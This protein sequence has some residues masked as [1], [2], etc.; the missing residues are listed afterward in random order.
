MG[1]GTALISTPFWHAKELLAEGRGRLF[2]FRNFDELSTILMEMFDDPDLLKQYKQKSATFGQGIIWPVSGEEYNSMLELVIEENKTGIVTQQVTKTIAHPKISF[3]HIRKLTDQTGIISHAVYGFPNLKNGY[4]MEDNARALFAAA[5]A[6]RYTGKNNLKPLMSTYLSFI[7]F[8]QNPDG[9]FKNHLLYNHTPQIENSSDEC[10]GTV[11]WALGYL[12]NNPPD[13]S[14]LEGAKEIFKKAVTNTEMLSQIRGIAYSILGLY[15]Y[16]EVFKTDQ[17]TSERLY[18]LT[19][20]LTNQYRNTKNTDWN[21]FET[22]IAYDNAVLPLALMVS[23]E[24]LQDDESKKMAFESMRFLTDIVIKEGR[25]SLIG[26]KKWYEKD[27][28]RSVFDQLPVDAMGLI[29]LYKRAFELTQNQRFYQ[30]MQIC[31]NW[32]YGHNDLYVSLYDTNTRGCYDGLQENGV[33]HNQGA[34][35]SL[36]FVTSNIAMHEVLS[37]IQLISASKP[38]S[39]T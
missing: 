18:S 6:Y 22:K 20:K 5:M 10:F 34:E 25:L 28:E 30:F 27:G 3:R 17:I 37:Q 23:S 32:F 26:N 21:W 1:A 38:K 9:T 16:L 39:V 15:H 8:M 29:L 14:F 33:N 36:A 19:R 12:I 13:Y 24:F 2:K 11:L 4:R 7:Q 35:S 31:F